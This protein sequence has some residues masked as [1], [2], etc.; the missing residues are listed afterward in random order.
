MLTIRLWS[1]RSPKEK[2]FGCLNEEMGRGVKKNGVLM[3]KTNITRTWGRLFC[4]WIVH[5]ARE[6]EKPSCPH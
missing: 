6:P 5:E 1:A 3:E 4:N 2:K